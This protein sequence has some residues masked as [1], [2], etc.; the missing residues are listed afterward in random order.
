LPRTL[1]PQHTRRR[2][3]SR[4]GAEP[5]LLFLFTCQTAHVSS[6]SRRVFAPGF[7]FLCFAHPNRGVAERRET[8]GCLRG[9]RWACAIGAGQAPSEAPCVPNGGRSPLGAPPWRFWAPARASLTGAHHKLSLGR[10]PDRI[11]RAPRAR[12][13]VPGRRGA[14]PPEATVANRNRGTPLLAPPSGSPLEDAPHERG[15]EPMYFSCNL[16]SSAKCRKRF[17][18]IW[19]LMQPTNAFFNQ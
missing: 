3:A 4:L 2:A 17:A 8:Y 9:I 14:G 19:I 13:V 10:G 5:R 18:S 11:Q 6:F 7:C 1:T 15:C 16:Q 12:V